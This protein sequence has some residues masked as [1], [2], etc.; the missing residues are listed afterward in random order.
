MSFLFGQSFILG[1][2]EKELYETPEQRRAKV[3]DVLSGADAVA[4]LR[5]EEDVAIGSRLNRTQPR[6]RS[7]AFAPGPQ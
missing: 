3:I 4:A 5:P 6:V 7:H 1:N 2:I